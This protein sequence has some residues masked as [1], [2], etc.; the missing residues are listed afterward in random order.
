[1]TFNGHKHSEFVPQKTAAYVGQNDL[2]VGQLTV[3]ETLDFS[4]N[5]QGVGP[6]YGTTLFLHARFL[7]KFRN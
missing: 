3:R 4:A 2:H 7:K 1:M 6:L 5:V